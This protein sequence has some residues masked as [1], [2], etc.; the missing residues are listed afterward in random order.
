MLYYSI[1]HPD[2]ENNFTVTVVPINGVKVASEIIIMFFI[3][4]ELII[5]YCNSYVHSII[6][7]IIR[8]CALQII[9]TI[10]NFHFKHS[11][12]NKL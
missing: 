5:I 11:G 10:C 1:D 7:T 12:I 8:N 9:Q 6:F 3:H 4:G 2:P